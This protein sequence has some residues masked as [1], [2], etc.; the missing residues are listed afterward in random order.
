MVQGITHSF[1]IYDVTLAHAEILELFRM[2]NQPSSRR[3]TKVKLTQML[4]EQPHSVR[5]PEQLVGIPDNESRNAKDAAT[6]RFADDRLAAS[7]KTTRWANH[8]KPVQPPLQKYFAS[9][10]TQISR[11]TPPVSRQMRGAR[12]RHE[13]AVRC[14]GHE[15]HD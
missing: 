15:S 6:L 4:F 2:L 14:D 7:D 13:R 3:T 10:E 11:I 1:L 8:Q 12:D 5:T 9:A